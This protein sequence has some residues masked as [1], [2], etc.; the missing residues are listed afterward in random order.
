MEPNV[1]SLLTTPST[2]TKR[3]SLNS[4]RLLRPETLICAELLKLS[5]TL[6]PT[7]AVPEMNKLASNKSSVNSP[8]SLMPS[9][10]RRL[11]SLEDPRLS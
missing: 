4:R 5:T 3:N 2:R 11:T 7:Y 10:L 6:K 9:L 1:S 8:V